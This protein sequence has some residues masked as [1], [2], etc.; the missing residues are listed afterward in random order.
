VWAGGDYRGSTSILV[1]QD[2][3]EEPALDCQPVVA[4]DKAKL[5]ELIHEMADPR[6]GCADHLC[7]VFLINS[8]Y[9]RLSRHTLSAGSPSRSQS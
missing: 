3:A 8:H 4:I 5:L 6:P 1:V 2:Y 9:H 7:Q